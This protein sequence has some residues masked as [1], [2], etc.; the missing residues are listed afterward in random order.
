MRK[1]NRNTIGFP[2]VV[3]L[4]DKMNIPSRTPPRTTSEFIAKQLRE[5]IL[6]GAL[7]AGEHLRQNHI[8]T[9]FGV[10]S[11]PVR[12]ALRELAAEGLILSSAHRGNIVR[13]LTISDVAEI[14]EL[15][16]LLE[17]MLL[18]R[19]F[20]TISKDQ[21]SACEDLVKRMEIETDIT[22][23]SQLNAQF[24][25]L[26]MGAESEQRLP[27]LVEMLSNAAMPYVTLSLYGRIDELK[28]SNSE[29]RALLAAYRTH[30]LQKVVSL[31]ELH[32]QTTIDLISNKLTDT[33][34]K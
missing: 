18:R 21:L 29:H 13:G 26:L 25:A 32:L 31:T 17:P 12:E 2:V 30:D 6:S 27:R 20:A 19:N 1:V 10:S 7:R 4:V 34:D 11:T 24:H 15:R 28:R 22:A 8:A 9:E 23:W 33:Q 5:D 3:S 16:L 14:Y